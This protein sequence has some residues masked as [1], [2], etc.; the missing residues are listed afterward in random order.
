MGASDRIKYREFADIMRATDRQLAKIA[1]D[2]RNLEAAIRNSYRGF[3]E[4]KVGQLLNQIPIDEINASKE[5]I[6]V[7]LLKEAGLQNVGDA[8]RMSLRALESIPGVGQGMASKIKTNANALKE[9]A[10]RKTKVGISLTCN[11]PRQLALLKDLGR[12]MYSSTFSERAESLYRATHDAIVGRL[13]ISECIGNGLKWFFAGSREKQQ[14]ELA[15]S[16]LKDYLVQYYGREANSI[17]SGYNQSMAKKD[18]EIEADFRNNSAP[19]YALLERMCEREISFNSKYG[20]IPEKL[21]EE[22]NAVPLKLDK[23]NANLRPYQEFG[24]KYAI[25]Q[26][27]VLL[28]DE[29]GLGKTIQAI[30][31]MVHLAEQGATHFLVICPLSVMVNWQREVTKFSEIAVDD[32][33]GYD[34]EEEL[35]SWVEHGGVAVTTYETASKIDLPDGKQIDLLVVDEA[36]YI[37]NPQAQRTKA[38]RNLLTRAER[39]LF[40]SGTPLENKVEEMNFLIS[41]LQPDIAKRVANLTSLAQAA[42][43]RN[44]V[45]PVYLRRTRE[46]VLTELPE[47]EEIENWGVLSDVE[48]QAY[49]KALCSDNFMEV[50][51]ISWNVEDINESTKAKR[52]MEIIEEATAD[53]RKVLVFSYFKKTLQKVQELLGE[54]CIGLIDGSM[55]MEARQD[56]LD[57]FKKED[58]PPV[59]IAQVIAGGVGLNIQCASVI[60][61]CEPQLKPSM[62][63]QAIGRAYR[64]GQNRN[65]LVHRLLISDSV[66]EK[67]MAILGE[68]EKIFDEF[69][70]ESVIGNAEQKRQVTAAMAES[71]IAEE[72][73]R[74][75]IDDSEVKPENTIESEEQFEDSENAE[76]K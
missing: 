53:G 61:F 44:E 41:G 58:M 32:I 74:L 64:M 23:L 31:S 42:Q 71:I 34:R 72:R 45:A 48:M 16:E 33:Y 37:K 73:K 67:I 17:I 4:E 26:K 56:L 54:A 1:Q 8:Y 52:L 7:N 18:S 3:Q 21:V 11:S 15:Y 27:R 19:F 47:K 30:A 70:Q 22:I 9:A 6:R 5:G 63:E 25:H 59:L 29:M 55:S 51:Q 24:V 13:Q 57:D 69:A 39:V 60:I 35:K 49:R 2:R 46:E 50:R 12:M 65:V 36:H 38:V 14:A 68:K 40:M 20:G 28:G 43:Y 66:D 62:E 76:D 75:G 10:M